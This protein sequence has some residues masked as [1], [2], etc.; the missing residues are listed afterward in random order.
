[1]KT[2]P[3]EL[4]DDRGSAAYRLVERGNPADDS[5]VPG[6]DDFNFDISPEILACV[7]IEMGQMT[8]IKPDQLNDKPLEMQ[9][10]IMDGLQNVLADSANLLDLNAMAEGL[11]LEL[12]LISD[13]PSL[14]VVGSGN[15][16]RLVITLPPPRRKF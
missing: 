1:M 2:N 14:Q 9:R 16:D 3:E 7:K 4:F 8:L 11:K 12:E 6:T 5:F 15:L 10:A 13:A